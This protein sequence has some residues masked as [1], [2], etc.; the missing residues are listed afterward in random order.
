[1]A[2]YLDEYGVAD[3]RKERLRKRIILWGLTA[4]IVGTSAFF[5]FRNWSEERVLD[6]FVTLLKEQKYQEAYQLW[7]TPETA[8]FYPPDKFAEDWGASGIY[9]NPA[10]L[11]IV[12]EDSCGDGVV[13]Q[14]A[15]PG[16][17]D[18][19][20]WVD[21]EKKFISYYGWPRC[22]GPHLEIW[23]FLKSHFGGGS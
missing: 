2:G 10:D 20:L 14:M 13:F 19:G 18:F 5:Y 6:H 3:A 7:L 16:A 21:R 12:V 15:Y 1:M 11:K 9:K 8:R 23:R 22:P 4:V 17:D